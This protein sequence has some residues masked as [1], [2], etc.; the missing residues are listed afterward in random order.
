MSQREDLQWFREEILEALIENQL[1]NLS[2]IVKNISHHFLKAK[3]MNIQQA[4][5][6]VK[7]RCSILQ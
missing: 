1:M 2:I 6:E 3:R 4:S 5:V 7:I